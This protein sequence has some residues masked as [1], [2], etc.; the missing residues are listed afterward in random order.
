MSEISIND[1]MDIS[2]KAGAL[3]LENGGETYRAEETCVR[4]AYALGATEA[5][6]F[7]TPTVVILSVSDENNICHTAMRRITNRTVNLTKI[8]LVN[9]LSRRL[10]SRGKITS[11]QQ[12]ERLLDRISKKPEHKPALL[13]LMAGFSAFFFALM[14]GADIKEGIVGF[15]IGSLLRV[16]LL[17]LSKFKLNSFIS[18]VICGMFISSLCEF[19]LGF[20]FLSSSVTVMTA[21]LMQVV[22]GMAIVNAIR[23][24]ISGDLMAGTARL[25]DAFMVAAGLSIGSAFGILV[26]SNVTS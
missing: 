22:P 11:T 20:G 13:V 25:V 6:S 1:V 24:L 14:F 18:S 12:A 23:D 9:D 17:L 7:V 2:I 21:V 3:I 15:I 10:V 19:A 16:A 26:F 8:A 4:V 5:H